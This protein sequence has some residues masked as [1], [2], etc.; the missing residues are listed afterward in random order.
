MGIEVSV[1]FELD[2][3]KT[4]KYATWWTEP[5]SEGDH[6]DEPYHTKCGL[7]FKEDP[8]DG[9]CGHLDCAIYAAKREAIYPVGMYCLFSIMIIAAG[10]YEKG[11]LLA[12]IRESGFFIVFG[13]IMLLMSVIPF[14][15]WL[16]LRE[17]KNH[18]TIHGMTAR[19]R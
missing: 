9:A 14:R 3:G 15:R 10:W 1:K 5:Y 18:G 17:Y 7:S 11:G 13:S 16:E 2:N 6:S 4:K 8:T 19:R 12:W